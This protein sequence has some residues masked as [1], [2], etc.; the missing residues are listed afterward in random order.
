MREKHEF[1]SC[2]VP[3]VGASNNDWGIPASNMTKKKRENL[4]V[5]LEVRGEL[6]GGPSPSLSSPRSWVVCPPGCRL[7][8]GLRGE[9]EGYAG[10]GE[11]RPGREGVRWGTRK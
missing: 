1:C 5:A 7:E 2:V 4:G 10:L 11:G 3:P 8:E 9:S 6:R